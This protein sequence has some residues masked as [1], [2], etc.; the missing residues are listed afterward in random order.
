MLQSMGSQ[1]VRH[2][3]ATNQQQQQVKKTRSQQKHENYKRKNLIIK[4]VDQALIKLEGRLNNKSHKI[5]YI[6]NK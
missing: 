1:R 4:L 6:H 5:I 3:L 2:N